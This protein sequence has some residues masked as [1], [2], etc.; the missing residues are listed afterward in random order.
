MLRNRPKINVADTFSCL[1][2]GIRIVEKIS[3]IL[4]GVIKFV[5]HRKRRGIPAFPDKY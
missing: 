3:I 5:S 2:S 4:R 1:D